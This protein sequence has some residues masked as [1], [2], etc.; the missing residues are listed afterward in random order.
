MKSRSHRTGSSLL[1]LGA[2]PEHLARHGRPRALPP[3]GPIRPRGLWGRAGG[4]GLAQAASSLLG[5][6]PRLGRWDRRCQV[7][8]MLRCTLSHLQG[9]LL[10]LQGRAGLRSPREPR[11]PDSLR[12]QPRIWAQSTSSASTLCLPRTPQGTPPHSVHPAG[13]AVLQTP[14]ACSLPRPASL[15]PPAGYPLPGL[16]PTHAHWGASPLLFLV[17]SQG[18][19]HRGLSVGLGGT[20]AHLEG[21]EC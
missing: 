4:A 1:L 6:R 2:G 3:Q 11:G 15:S 12:G 18:S 8:S 14:P 9:L 13:R 17:S 5:P 16:L 21:G 20:R 19:Q 10:T 7:Q